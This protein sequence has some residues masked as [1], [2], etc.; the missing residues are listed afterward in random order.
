MIHVTILIAV[1]P[2]KF[3]A[4]DSLL[5]LGKALIAKGHEITG[6]FLFGSGVYNAKCNISCGRDT[7]NLPLRLA[8]FCNE[9]GIE[10]AACSNWVSLTG[11]T[12]KDLIKGACQKGLGQLE[13]WMGRSDRLLVFG[14]GA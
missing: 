6:I 7:R 2:Y 13:E 5:N 14:A 11:L 1:E 9:H 8:E 12:E 4:L 10:V 3:E